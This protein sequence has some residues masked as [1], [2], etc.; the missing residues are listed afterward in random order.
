M[1]IQSNCLVGKVGKT[2]MFL[3][4]NLGF[5]NLMFTGSGTEGPGQSSHVN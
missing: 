4:D 1:L 5:A 3:T 2:F